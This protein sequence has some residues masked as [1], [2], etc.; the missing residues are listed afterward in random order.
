MIC[1]MMAYGCA[2]KPAADDKALA[3]VGNQT[4]MVSDFKGRI[5]KLPDYYKKVVTQNKKR[6]LDELI[7]EMMFYEDAVRSGID[8]SRE[9]DDIV[10]EAKKKIVI[11]KFIKNEVEDK[12]VVDDAEIKAFYD[13]HKEESKT[14]QMWRAS[15]ILVADEQSAKDILDQLKNGA[16][17]QK[18]AAERSTDATAGRGGDIGYFR[19][20]QLV[21]DFEKACI[22]LSVGE[23]SGV[24]HTQFGYHIIKLTDKKDPAVKSYEEVKKLIEAELKKKKRSE[25]FDALVMEMKNKYG[26]TIKE[27]VFRSLDAVE[28]TG[29]PQDANESS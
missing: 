10:K 15:H 3:T 13:E 4:I 5:D 8:K 2:K 14:P 16:D 20:G 22:A 21:P 29:S 18:L 25:R 11:A 9:I 12:L 28:A 23:T 1:L 17:F 24:V 19:Q 27:D 7:I 6:Y 26:V